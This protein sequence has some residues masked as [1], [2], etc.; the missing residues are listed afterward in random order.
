[1]SFLKALIL[2]IIATLLLTY[3]LGASFLE[4]LGIDVANNINVNNELMASFK[5]IS[6]SALAAILAIVVIVTVLLG[7]FGIVFCIAMFVVGAV[8]AVMLGAFWPLCLLVFVIWAIT[9][10]SKSDV[11]SC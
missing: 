1:M 8:F 9:R 4:L 10:E 5:T 2:A 11:C 7:V 6:F 3:F